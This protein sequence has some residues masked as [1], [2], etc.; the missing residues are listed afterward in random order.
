M[1]K[2]VVVEDM[3]FMFNDPDDIEIVEEFD[4]A[5]EAYSY[6]SIKFQYIEWEHQMHR[7][8]YIVEREVE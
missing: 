8:L 1:T 5:E 4:T 7:V 6:L 2:Y 3:R